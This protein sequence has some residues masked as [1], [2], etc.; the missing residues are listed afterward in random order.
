MEGRQIRALGRTN[1]G[2]YEVK[3]LDEEGKVIK[4]MK[5]NNRCKNKLCGD[6][7]EWMPLD[8]SLFSDFLLAQRRNIAATI[9]LPE[10]HPDKFQTNTPTKK[11]SR[12][13]LN[14]LVNTAASACALTAAKLW[15]AKD[16]DC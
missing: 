7:P 2:C 1:A 11:W 16:A 12:Q 5:L 8:S 6:H 9:W 14:T 3:V 4:I 15:G 10:G 13:T